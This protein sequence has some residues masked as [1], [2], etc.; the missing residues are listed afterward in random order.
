MVRYMKVKTCVVEMVL[1]LLLAAL[2]A[3]GTALERQQQR[4]S[5]SLIRLHVVAASDSQEDQEI[6][7]Q[8][9]DA[10]LAELEPI[11]AGA[12]DRTEAAALLGENLDLLAQTANDRLSTLGSQDTAS[13]RYAR[14]LFGTRVYDSFSLPGGYYDALRV[15]IGPAEGKNWWCV[16]YPQICTAATIEDQQ[17]V[18]VMGGM[19]SSDFA[20]LQQNSTEYQFR[21][22]SLELLENLLGWFRGGSDGIPTSG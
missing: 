7:L 1:L 22:K 19:E 16:V 11:L 14:E 20:I 3:W 15:E 6:K 17:T 21:F 18:A 12:S 4:I 9:R 13:V 5:D 10:V 8:V 2:L